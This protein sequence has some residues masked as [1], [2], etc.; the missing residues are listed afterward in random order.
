MRTDLVQVENDFDFLWAQFDKKLSYPLKNLD[1]NCEK[2]L[3]LCLVENNLYF[4]FDIFT[5]NI[6]KNKK[7]TILEII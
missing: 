2:L 4:D 1:I 5:K 7:L 3:H 6:F